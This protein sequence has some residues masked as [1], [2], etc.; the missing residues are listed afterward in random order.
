MTSES[1]DLLRALPSVDELAARLSADGHSAGWSCLVE[2][3]RTGI[4]Q[5]RDQ[6]VG[7][8]ADEKPSGEVADSA[9]EAA[10]TALIA[11]SRSAYR[12]AIN[13]TGIVLHTNLGRAVLP[14]TAIQAIS[15]QL[16]G[17]SLLQVDLETGRRGRRDIR[18]QDLLH[19]LTGAEAATVVNNNAAATAL[20][21]N[22]LG[23]DREVIVSRGQLVEIG[24]SF[25]LPEVMTAAGV[26]LVEVGSTNRT[27]ARDYERAIGPQ[28][29]ALLR[30]H[31]SN[32]RI[33]GFTA[34]VS[35]AEMVE[36][37]HRHNLPLIDDVGAGALIDGLG[38]PD[39]PQPTLRDSIEA[40]ADLVVCS[41][42]KLIGG[43]Q[44]GLVLGRRD[45][46]EA[47]R[48]NPL[49][50]AFRVDKLTLTAL[51]ATLSLFLDPETAQQVP[52]MAMLAR[53]L[54]QLA[55]AAD[56]LAE[57]INRTRPGSA[58]VVEG[59]SEAGSGSLPAV[60]LPTRLVAVQPPSGMPEAEFARRLRGY[61]PPIVARIADGRLLID[62]RTLL[63]G[64]AE[65]VAAAVALLVS[66][67]CP[68]GG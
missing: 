6:I 56:Q 38:P 61:E 37:A 50:R 17:Y 5:V 15:E 28:T 8:R 18:I 34:E 57:R 30:V 13:A 67:T 48:S 68:N 39:H 63:E 7:G 10:R 54:E 65:I 24:G 29:A 16:A 4:R 43:P 45:L 40:G 52:T 12:R 59:F 60:G 53:P 64:E 11:M 58:E 47:C 9:Y 44:C 22:T 21:L 31:P 49:A 42:D 51:E 23:R 33:E 1:R 55:V 32:Y 27:H 62:P 35:L 2:A 3:A 19:Q 36:I 25:R 66:P 46:I 20:V 41:G 26:H 14:A